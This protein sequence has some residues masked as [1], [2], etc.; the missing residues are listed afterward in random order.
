MSL[1]KFLNM[2]YESFSNEE[3]S[4]KVPE[5][6]IYET[7]QGDQPHVDNTISQMEPLSSNNDTISELEYY[8][9]LRN[10]SKENRLKIV[11]ETILQY[12]GRN[13]SSATLPANV[14]L[15]PFNVSEVLPSF[16]NA[17]VISSDDQI[18]EKIRSF[19]PSC[20]VPANT[21]QELWKDDDIMNLFFNFDYI[22]DNRNSNLATAI[23][24]LY[25]IPGNST[26]IYSRGDDCGDTSTDD[27]KLFRVSVYRYTKPLKRR[28][29]KRLLSDSKVITENA[30]WVELNVK[31]ATSAWMKGKNSG[32]AILVEDQE[33]NRLRADKF[34]KGATCTVGTSTPKPIPTIVIDAARKSNELDRILGRNSTTTATLHSDIY[35]LPTIDICIMELPENYTPS[36]P[37]VN[38]QKTACN[39]KKVFELNQEMV[40]REGLERISSLQEHSLP[41][42]RHIRHQRQHLIDRM[43]QE[44]LNR[45]FDPRSRIVGS[46]IILRHD[47][48]ENLTNSS[49]NF[50]MINR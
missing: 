24:R 41:S 49:L 46:K 38:W 33:G 3:K 17:S 8:A 35:L 14:T 44:G 15:P 13:M 50:S 30:K 21:D 19:Y 16:Y 23:L 11:K 32:L 10:R 29:V 9:A 43:N 27:E 22:S 20:D 28:R 42:P 4:S 5:G 48:L 39:L 7:M 47:E 12:L 40:E 26:Q 18:S 1:E 25:R 2:Y 6:D 37:L 36:D 34:F 45:E 31:P